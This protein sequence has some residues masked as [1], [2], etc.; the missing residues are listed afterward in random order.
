MLDD[1]DSRLVTIGVKITEY[2]YI[3]SLHFEISLIIDL[4]RLLR[5]GKER[6]S[7]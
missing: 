4:E 1:S 7:C 6:E 5:E 3:Q 2:G